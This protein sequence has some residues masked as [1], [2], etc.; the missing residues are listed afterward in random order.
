MKEKTR[1]TSVN[2]TIQIMHTIIPVIPV[3]ELRMIVIDNT[4]VRSNINL[5][6]IFFPFFKILYKK[7]TTKP[8]KIHGIDGLSMPKKVY[9]V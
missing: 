8:H 7:K 6:V 3:P 5:G 4:T 9:L 2:S 1:G